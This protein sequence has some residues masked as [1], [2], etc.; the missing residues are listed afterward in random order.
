MVTLLLAAALS[1][2]LFPPPFEVA[3]PPRV[4]PLTAFKDD[5][6]CP[7]CHPDDLRCRARAALAL[8]SAK[9]QTVAKTVPTEG[10]REAARKALAACKTPA[11]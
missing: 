9:K 6:D 3:P 4:V 1:A 7:V 2:E 11:P 10:E 8:A 5:D